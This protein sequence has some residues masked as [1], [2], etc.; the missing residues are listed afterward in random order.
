[1]MDYHYLFQN[2]VKCNSTKT[3]STEKWKQMETKIKE[4]KGMEK[5]GNVSESTDWEKGVEGLHVH[6]WCCIRLSSKRS[7]QHLWKRTEKKCWKNSSD[8]WAI[9]FTGK[10]CQLSLSIRLQSSIDGPLYDKNKFIWCME[11][12]DKKNPTRKI[13]ANINSLAMERIQKTIVVFPVI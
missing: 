3:I 10:K 12:S 11:G 1:M 13:D 9:R 6:K 7:L 8:P 2:E 4:W 5:F